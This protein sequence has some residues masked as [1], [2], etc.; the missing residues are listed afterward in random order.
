MKLSVAIMTLIAP[1]ALSPGCALL[2]ADTVEAQTFTLVKGGKVYGGL[3]ALDDGTALLALQ[4]PAHGRAAE[5]YSEPNSGSVALALYDSFGQPGL[6]VGIDRKSNRPW[7]WMHSRGAGSGMFASLSKNNEM[8]YLTL[9]SEKAHFDATLAAVRMDTG[10]P[11][12][13]LTITDTAGNIMGC[14]LVE[15]DGKTWSM[16]EKTGAE[17]ANDPTIP[18]MSIQDKDFLRHVLELSTSRGNFKHK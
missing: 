11:Q 16:S 3:T 4:D 17:S 7:L 2:R 10:T 18:G 12:L 5:L 15:T 8:P 9:Y 14:F 13:Q 6:R 1:V